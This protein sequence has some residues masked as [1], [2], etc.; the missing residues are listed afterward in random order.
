MPIH[1]HPVCSFI[2]LRIQPLPILLEHQNYTRTVVL[3]DILDSRGFKLLTKV[4]LVYSALDFVVV[5]IIFFVL[6]D[7]KFDVLLVY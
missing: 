4:A 3:P 2:F 5:F 1:P 7:R 6:P